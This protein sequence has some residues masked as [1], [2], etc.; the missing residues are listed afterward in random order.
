MTLIS[1]SSMNFSNKNHGLHT[2]IWLLSVWHHLLPWP[3][4]I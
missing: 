4:Q 1:P 3:L 2:I